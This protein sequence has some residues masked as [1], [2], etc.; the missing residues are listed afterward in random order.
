MRQTLDLNKLSGRLHRRLPSDHRVSGLKAME[1]AM[2]KA[3]KQHEYIYLISGR[4]HPFNQAGRRVRTGQLQ[5][6]QH[7]ADRPY[8]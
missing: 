2:T 5:Q 4:V 1:T 3:V 7:S 8:R 6:P